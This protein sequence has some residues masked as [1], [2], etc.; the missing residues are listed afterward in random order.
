MNKIKASKILFYS[1]SVLYIF[2]GTVYILTPTIMPYHSKYLGMTHEELIALSPNFVSL[3]LMSLRII[4]GQLF[5]VAVAIAVLSWKFK[6]GENWMP[7][8]LAAVSICSLLPLLYVTA[9]VG[10]S[11]PWWVIVLAIIMASAATV[12]ML[13]SGGKRSSLL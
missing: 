4:G 7:L 6:E 8:T 13:L 2:F 3:S 1:I 12:L 5:A 10:I 11:S 9:S